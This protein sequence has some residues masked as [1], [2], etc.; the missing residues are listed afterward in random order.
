MASKIIKN[1]I[2]KKFF[3]LKTQQNKAFCKKVVFI[4][5]IYYNN[6]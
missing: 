3:L 5:N 1:K 2:K 4:Y 6:K